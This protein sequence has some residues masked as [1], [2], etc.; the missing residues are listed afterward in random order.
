V[1]NIARGKLKQSS[2]HLMQLADYLAR[3]PLDHLK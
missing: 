1:L 2:L 3:F